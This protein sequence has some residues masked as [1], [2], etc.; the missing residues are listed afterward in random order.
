MTGAPSKGSRIA[1]GVLEKGVTRLD[2]ARLPT[3]ARRIARLVLVR[4]DA[5]RRLYSLDP[6]GI[7][8]LQAWLSAIRRLWTRRLDDLER[9]LRG[10][11][12][13]GGR[14]DRES[15]WSRGWAPTVGS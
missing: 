1:R 2:D 9:D 5:Q 8:E 3:R 4:V 6:K 13:L 15:D 12:H 11:N 14:N 10:T 7:E